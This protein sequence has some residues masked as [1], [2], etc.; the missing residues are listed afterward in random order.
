VARAPRRGGGRLRHPLGVSFLVAAGI[1]LL[2]A[3]AVWI[4][5][6]QRASSLERR[7]EQQRRASEAALR[8]SESRYR[9]L[10]ENSPDLYA[11]VDVATETIADCNHTLAAEL[12][13]EKHELIG[14]PAR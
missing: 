13:Y 9:D 4:A 8:E 10:Y 1:G 2:A 11:S 7:R 5:G 12:G 14:F 6:R 3:T